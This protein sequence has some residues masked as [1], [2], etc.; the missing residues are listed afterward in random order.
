LTGCQLEE[1]AGVS[2]FARNG[3][4]I[5]GELAACQ[6]YYFRWG[7]TNNFGRMALGFAGSLTTGGLFFVQHPV[8]M[9][10]NPTAL[11]YSTLAAWDQTTL[12]AITSLTIGQ[13]ALNA[14]SVD[15]ATTGLTAYRPYELLSNSSSSAFF[16]LTA[17]L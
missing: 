2:A 10:T 16:A 4:T 15:F 9:R 6:R 12:R 17:E 14:T 3:A 7:G 11:E 1:A 8:Q 13:A 5:Q